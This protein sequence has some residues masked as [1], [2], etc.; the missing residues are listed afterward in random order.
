MA[1]RLGLVALIDRHLPTSRR[2]LSIGT[3]LVLAAIN[4]AVWPCSK[5]AWAA[6]AQRT[7]LH[8]LFDI[9]PEALTSQYFW[10]QMDAVS[11]VALEA[12]E[13]ELTRTVVH[14]FQLKLDTLFYDTSN[15]FT[16]LASGNERSAVAQR[17]H[18]KQKRFDL[19]QFSL[20]L[21]V[22]RDGQIPLYADLYEGNT[23]DAT[24]FPAS[25]TAIR[26]RVERLVGQLEDLTLVYDKGNNS[27]H[28]Q[29]LVDHSPCTMW[30]PSSPANTLTSV[31]F[32]RRHTPPWAPGR[33][34]RSPC[35]AVNT[36]SGAWSGRWSSSSAPAAQGPNTGA[37]PALDQTG[38]GPHPVAT[39]LGQTAQWPAHPRQRP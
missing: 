36:P 27:K 29:A 13:A 2:P 23:V 24:R 1:D 38:G 21:L 33:W 14:D 17:G 16:Y 11:G 7:S 39:D 37:P 31:P 19:R 9:H 30:P 15:F 35:I 6:W 5:R 25:L 3:T 20:A 34:P 4:R 22:A 10:D 26:Q 28:N 12:I 8:R 18:S 32:P